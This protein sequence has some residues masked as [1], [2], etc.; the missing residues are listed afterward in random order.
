LL[1]ALASA[2][3]LE[4]DTRTSLFVASYDSQGYGGGIIALLFI[5]PIISMGTCLFAKAYLA[6]AACT[7]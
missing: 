6:T 1:L 3:I 4:S 5:T 7:S 2:V